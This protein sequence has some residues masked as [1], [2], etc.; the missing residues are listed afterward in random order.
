MR[1]EGQPGESMATAYLWLTPEEAK[2]LMGTLGQLLRDADYGAHHHVSSADFQTEL[3][4]MLD[5]A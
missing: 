4:V 2:K 3:T 1:I 5:R